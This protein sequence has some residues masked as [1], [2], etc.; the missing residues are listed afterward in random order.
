MGNYL[1]RYGVYDGR[2][3]D[4]YTLCEKTIGAQKHH[5]LPTYVPGARVS[6]TMLR[7]TSCD[8]V[9]S[10]SFEA[11]EFEGSLLTVYERSKEPS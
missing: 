7:I 11:H 5:R 8:G 6:Q 10:L 1:G 3:K 9:V 2:H 4:K